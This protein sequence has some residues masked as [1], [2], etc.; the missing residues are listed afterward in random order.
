MHTF[1]EWRDSGEGFECNDNQQALYAFA[2]QFMCGFD[3]PHFD[4]WAASLPGCPSC[5]TG[6]ECCLKQEM[7]ERRTLA[8]EALLANNKDGAFRHLEWMLNRQRGDEREQFL[9]PLAKRDKKRQ[10]GTK[11]PRRPEINDWI[12]RKL[13]AEPQARSPALWRMAPDWITDQIGEDRFSKRVTQV[14]KELSGRK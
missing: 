3:L 1:P 2:C 13:K 6:A 14:R 4:R 8:I 7:R 12:K 11:Q 9:L 5:G 10:D